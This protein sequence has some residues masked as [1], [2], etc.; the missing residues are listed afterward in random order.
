MRPTPNPRDPAVLEEE[1]R[2]YWTTRHLPEADGL[3]AP[4]GG[5]ASVTLLVSTIVRGLEGNPET[6]H[7]LL[8]ADI[9]ARYL[10]LS[11]RGLRPEVTTESG[12]ATTGPVLDPLLDRLGIWFGRTGRRG[13][14]ERPTGDRLQRAIDR[15]A[16]S[17][18]LVARSIVQRF[19][20]FCAE[21]RTPQR[22]RYRDEYGRAYLVRVPLAEP[23]PAP[24]LIV[25]TEA[26]WKLL[27]TTAILL[28]PDVPYVRATFRR[29]GAEEQILIA[30]AALPRLEE[31]MPGGE[32]TILEERPG[33]EWAGRRYRSPLADSV[34]SLGMVEPPVGTIQPTP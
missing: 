18:L 20:S 16:E 12:A 11:G 7:R 1:I 17:E 9:A 31:W 2:S 34:P 5:A 22:V 19:C 30:K 10:R 13:A 28:N 4:L 27:S 25:W 3:R 21:V 14:L 26:V 24:S 29:R 32:T 15:F 8:L 33:S 6:I 23:A